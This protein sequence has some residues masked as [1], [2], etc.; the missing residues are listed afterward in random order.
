MATS[1]LLGPFDISQSGTYLAQIDATIATWAAG[2]IC[3]P[4]VMANRKVY[5]LI[6]DIL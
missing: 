5:F 4:V 6:I 2:D 3:Q 1:K